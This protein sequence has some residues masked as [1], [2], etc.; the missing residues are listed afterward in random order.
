MRI[1]LVRHFKVKQA[2]PGKFLLTKSEVIKWFDGYESAEVESKEVDLY[3]INWKHCYAS[4]LNRAVKT[5]GRIYDGETIQISELKELDILHLLTNRIRLPFMI[6]GILVRI[7]SLKSNTETNEF[8]N[9]IA[10][11][12]DELVLKNDT[13]ILIVSHWFVMQVLQKELIKKGFKGNNF[14]SPDYGTVYIFE[15]QKTINR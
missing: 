9:K 2:Y 1:G 12:V 15:K 6:W 8:K 11:F 3:G 5:A 4:P 10:A 7:K 13:D 14:R